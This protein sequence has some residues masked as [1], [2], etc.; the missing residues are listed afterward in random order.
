MM[1]DIKKKLK[2]DINIQIAAKIRNIE[3]VRLHLA[4]GTDVNTQ[5]ERGGT[6]LH[7]AVAK[8]HREVVELLIK[9]GADINALSEALLC[10][11]QLFLVKRK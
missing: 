5:R 8:G 4:T 7:N 11:I 9:E 3:S 6:A 2:P 1:D 10:I